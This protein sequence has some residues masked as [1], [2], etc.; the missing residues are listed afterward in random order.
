[1]LKL[2]DLMNSDVVSV[3]PDLTLRELLEVFT[4]LEV[5]GAPV[6]TGGQV[7][8]VISMTDV[9]DL[10]EENGELMLR[11]GFDEPEASGRKRSGSQDSWDPSEEALDWARAARSRDL[12]LLDQYTVADVM[13]REVLS[14]PSN[15]PVKKAAHHMLGLGISR[16]LVI[17]K[18]ELQGIVTTTDIVRA[19]AEGKLK[20]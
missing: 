2:K 6:V 14:R 8:G 1:M 10:Q 3:S 12:D 4:E 20:G 11:P 17:D 16:I 18:G 7:V 19:V 9:F 15:T 5:S 13:T